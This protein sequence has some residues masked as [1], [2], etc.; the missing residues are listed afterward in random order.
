MEAELQ[1]L[2]DRLAKAKEVFRDMD[3]KMKEKDAKLS[4]TEAQLNTM[5]QRW[6]EADNYVEQLKRE[7]AELIETHKNEK[8]ILN[9]DIDDAK[10]YIDK[11][12][13][14][15]DALNAELENVKVKA[16]EALDKSNTN[17]AVL[18]EKYDKE[19]AR[20]QQIINDNLAANK[21]LTMRNDE[22]DGLATAR[23]TDINKLNED[24]TKLNEV[25]ETLKSDSEELGN[26]RATITSLN[27]Q[28]T[29][30]KQQNATT[31]SHVEAK[32]SEVKKRLQALNDGLGEEFNIF[33]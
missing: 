31:K 11:L 10:G 29:E 6:K 13:A 4:E 25:I 21:D 12:S 15:N 16:R 27:A 22:L 8:L 2:Q 9:H 30:L 7:K 32:V 28:I 33:G 3:A 24:I 20:L 5:E 17:I 26:A 19:T 23:L 18:Q 1:K 14:D